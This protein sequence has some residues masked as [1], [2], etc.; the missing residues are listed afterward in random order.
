MNSDRSARNIEWGPWVIGAMGA[1]LLLL[2]VARF[3]L[4][5]HFDY[6]DALYCCL[7]IVPAGIGFIV[8]AY[9]VQHAKWVSLLPLFAAGV[10]LFSYPVFDVALGLTL[11]GT[12]AGPALREW[13]AKAPPPIS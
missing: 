3:F 7:A 4:R 11:L 1:A 6:I 13:R 9:V 12:I 10:L 5:H 2:G 8:I